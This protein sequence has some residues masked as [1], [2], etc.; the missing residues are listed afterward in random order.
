MDHIIFK[1][2][3][4]L[5]YIYTYQIP[6]RAL[7]L[8]DVIICILVFACWQPC[9][10]SKTENLFRTSK[11]FFIMHFMAII[12]GIWQNS[13]II[14]QLFLCNVEETC[15]SYEW[16]D[17]L[18]RLLDRRAFDIWAINR[19]SKMRLHYDRRGVSIEIIISG[20][21]LWIAFDIEMNALWGEGYIN[22]WRMWI[23]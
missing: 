9:M 6:V 4:L 3:I 16:A 13:N 2:H 17:Q 11:L 20:V 19:K 5:T 8:L 7:P 12:N 15:H 1:K 21:E 22:R 18:N 14:F 10:C 23:E